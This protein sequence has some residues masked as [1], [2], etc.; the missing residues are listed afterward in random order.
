MAHY[1]RFFSLPQFAVLVMELLKAKGEPTPVLF[2]WEG[3]SLVI[4]QLNTQECFFR[5]GRL[6]KESMERDVQQH[7]NFPMARSRETTKGREGLRRD[8]DPVARPEKGKGKGKG[9]AKPRLP[10]GCGVLELWPVWTPFL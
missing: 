5:R 9:K 1:A 8:F 7:P 10:A 2:G 4:D 3:T 6:C